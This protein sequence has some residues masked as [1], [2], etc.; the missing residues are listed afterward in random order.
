[1]FRSDLPASWLVGVVHSVMHNAADEIN[2]GR[3][4]EA[5][6]PVFITATVLAAFTP[7]GHQVLT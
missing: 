2:A 4:S 7:P 1:V 5:E 3:L 6:A